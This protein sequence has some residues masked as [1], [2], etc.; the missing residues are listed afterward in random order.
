[1]QS[2]N[3][4]THHRE[5]IGNAITD[6]WQDVVLCAL[7]RVT[8]AP[9][10]ATAIGE[11]MLRQA[12]RERD[13]ERVAWCRTLIG[14]AQFGKGHLAEAIALLETAL[15]AL[16]RYGN[17]RLKAYCLHFLGGSYFN[18]GD[19]P[20]GLEYT[21]Q[22]L[23]LRRNQGNDQEL[24]ASVGAYGAIQGALGNLREAA[25]AFTEALEISRR[26]NDRLGQAVNLGNLGRLRFKID[27]ESDETFRYLSE[28][29]RLA[30]ELGEKRLLVTVLTNQAEAL[31]HRGRYAEAHASA[32]RAVREAEQIPASR[33]RVHAL[34]QLAA[35]RI[36]QRQ[37]TEAEVSLQRAQTEAENGHLTAVPR[38]S[39]VRGQLNKAHGDLKQAYRCYLDARE[40]AT[41]LG[42]KE[43]VA[44]IER[45]LSAV[46]EEMGDVSTA[47]RHFR[48]F[49]ELQCAL[50]RRSAQNL[51]LAEHTRAMIEQ[52]QRETELA[53]A[54]AELER[55][56]N[57]ELSEA[58][59][60]KD[61]R[62]H[63][64]QQQAN[65]LARLAIEDPLT[66]LYNRRYLMEYLTGELDRARRGNYPV[67]VVLADLDNFKKVN[68]RFSHAVGDEVLKTTAQILRQSC[69]RGDVAARYGGEEFVVVLPET[70]AAGAE[71]LCERIRHGIENFGWERYHPDL[72]VTISLGIAD[73][74]LR[75][76]DRLLALADR[77]QYQ[78][79]HDGKNRIVSRFN[80]RL[81]DMPPADACPFGSATCPSF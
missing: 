1:M 78:A 21:Y 50:D 35:V 62:L 15:S 66:G 31:S 79:K 22:A 55:L 24:T 37:W 47:L 2:T 29:I 71:I 53:R 12:E 10:E 48:A 75:Q 68:D 80:E 5:T 34:L 17:H 43:V 46:S 36:E 59:R 40:Q 76:P 11:S 23:T 25:S 49:H 19:Y 73:E 69:R 44:G 9:D 60:E 26:A 57:R 61:L 32:Q 70:D 16:E 41:T 52:A 67:T 14:A 3:G 74:A 72:R 58:N 56:R 38:L 8:I 27:P 77:R 4:D 45:V 13:D 39:M 42:E 20:R 63:Q 65:H 81:V 33:F 7:S 51:L 54:E 64:L 18:L 30:E 28:S 6:D